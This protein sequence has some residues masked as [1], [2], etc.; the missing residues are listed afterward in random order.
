[1]VTRVRNNPKSKF[2][3]RKFARGIARW[4]MAAPIFPSTPLN[5]VDSPPSTPFIYFFLKFENPSKLWPS[6]PPRPI[7]QRRRHYHQNTPRRLLYVMVVIA[8]ETDARNP[9]KPM[10]NRLPPPFV[11]FRCSNHKID[12][13]YVIYASKQV[14]STYRVPRTELVRVSRKTR[15]AAITV[16][17]VAP[18]LLVN[19]SGHRWSL[20][21]PGQ[22]PLWPPSGD[23]STQSPP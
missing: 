4:H 19:V 20:F 21:F 10:M 6:A 14:A 8:R 7:A 22:P 12:V 1:M 13:K 5:P 2:I 18:Q 15:R 9:T 17:T 3:V 23:R 11:T 16:A